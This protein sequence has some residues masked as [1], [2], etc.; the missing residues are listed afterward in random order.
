M[1]TND[2]V[3]TKIELIKSIPKNILYSSCFKQKNARFQI[4]ESGRS[5]YIS[6]PISTNAAQ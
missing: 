2:K 6:H 3:G 4:C 1:A 5:G